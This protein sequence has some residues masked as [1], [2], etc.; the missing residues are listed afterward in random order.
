VCTWRLLGCQVGT[1]G[2]LISG[3]GAVGKVI[4][5]IVIEWGEGTRAMWSTALMTH[6][7]SARSTSDFA[8]KFWRAWDCCLATSRML[9]DCWR[10][11]SNIA[12]VCWGGEGSSA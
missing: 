5:V 8:I 12:W 7:I 2:F 11:V 10:T 1:S 4:V 6:V 9:M 3:A